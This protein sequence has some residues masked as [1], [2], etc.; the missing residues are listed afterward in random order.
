M[1]RADVEGSDEVSCYGDFVH[2]SSG[3]TA[4]SNQYVYLRYM[5]LSCS[6]L[7]EIQSCVL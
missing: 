2:R 5:P 7:E 4:H 6:L 3:D 1:M